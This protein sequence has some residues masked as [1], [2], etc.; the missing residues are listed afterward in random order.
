MQVEVGDLSRLIVQKVSPQ[1]ELLKQTWR[2][3]RP[4]QHVIV[5]DFLPSEI[6]LLIQKGF[7]RDM[8]RCRTIRESKYTS[9]K[10]DTWGALTRAVFLAIQTD[11]VVSLLSEITGIERL[12]SDAT[13]WAGGLSAMV[14]GDFLN[15]HIDNSG[16]PN[17]RGWRRL[18]GLY[19]VTPDWRVEN[20]GNLELWSRDMSERCE[21]FSQFNRFV[22]MNTNR[23]S[24]HSVN[25]VVVAHS[26]RLCLSSYYYN[27][28]SPEQKDYSHVTCFRGRPEQPLRDVVLRAEGVVRSFVRRTFPRNV[29]RS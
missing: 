9:A 22:L 26:S 28:E 13:A 18:N 29:N 20:G 15:P 21:I 14:Q 23:A 1:L 8:L 2:R 24:L 12:N 5:D 19:Y 10:A 16:H 27:D 25:E 3:A 17:I 6:A 4:V 7:P 11:E